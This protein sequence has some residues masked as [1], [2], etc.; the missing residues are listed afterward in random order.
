MKRITFDTLNFI[1]MDFRVFLDASTS[2]NLPLNLT[3]VLTLDLAKVS[4]RALPDLVPGLIHCLSG[5]MMKDLNS[6]KGAVAVAV[7]RAAA[8]AIA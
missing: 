2:D 7:M 4:K 5:V 1:A 6:R 3:L 8:A